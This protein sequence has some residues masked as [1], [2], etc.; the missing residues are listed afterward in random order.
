M[1][2]T[3]LDIARLTHGELLAGDPATA[4]SSYSIDS[5][6][7]VAGDCFVALRDVRDGHAFVADAFARGARLALVSE[8]V[9]APEGGA[10]VKVA[11][12]LVALAALARRVRAHLAETTVVAITG[13]AG[14][15]ATKD[16]AASALA[17]SRRVHAS[18]LSFNNESGLPLTVLSAPDDTEV[19][20]V[21]MGARFPGNIRSLVEIAEPQIGVITHVGMAHAEHLGG[22][23]GIAQVKGE[24]VEALP[25]TGVAILNATCDESAGLAARTSARVV[26]V[27]RTSDADVVITGVVLDQELRAHFQ[28]ETPWGRA[29]ISLA[30]RG[31]HQVENAAM[32]AAVALELGVPLEAVVAG[33][34]VAQTASRRMELVHAPG[35]VTVIND[36]YNSSPTSAAAAVRSLAHLPVTGRRVAVLGPMLELGGHAH[37]EHAALGALAAAS[38]IDVVVAVGAEAESLAEGA[39][40]AA[41]ATAVSVVTVADAEAATGF[42]VGEVHAGDAVLVKASR[43]VG[44]ESVADA[45]IRGV[46]A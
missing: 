21:E 35:G 42:L 36:A 5:R 38:G 16:L 12:P 31:E 40:A 27:G 9:D 10:V 29:P 34:E 19:L 45:L 1:E 44:L 6:T 20:V 23:T 25:T 41:S 33:L 14:K 17:A 28:L 2:L 30:L 22:R 4:V 24:L 39:R 13:S 11:D 46:S 26:R 3:A 32:A 7:L 37:D 43:A 18:P 15:T 8:P